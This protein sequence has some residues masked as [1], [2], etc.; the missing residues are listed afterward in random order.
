MKKIRDWKTE[1]DEQDFKKSTRAKIKN[2]INNAVIKEKWSY[3][4]EAEFYSQNQWNLTLL[5]KIKEVNKVFKGQALICS[6]EAFAVLEDTAFSFNNEK[7]NELFNFD[8]SN[9][10]KYVVEAEIKMVGVFDGLFVFLD[11]YIPA[12]ILLIVKSDFFTSDNPDC[13]V[14][15]IDNLF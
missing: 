3:K 4:P 13:A 2:A 5:D 7:T 14:I 1:K 15:F 12:K 10:V 9:T 8:V 11:Y 6:P